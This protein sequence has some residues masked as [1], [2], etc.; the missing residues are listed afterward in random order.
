[1]TTHANCT[2]PTTPAARKACRAGRT[3]YPSYGT[4]VL[5]IREAYMD[6]PAHVVQLVTKTAAQV[7]EAKYPGAVL[8]GNGGFDTPNGGS[9]LFDVVSPEIA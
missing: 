5:I 8:D 2:H 7:I 1:M 4:R 6:C 3:S 9:F